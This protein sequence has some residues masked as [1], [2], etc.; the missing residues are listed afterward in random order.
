[1]KKIIFM[2]CYHLGVNGVLSSIFLY[3]TVD[4]PSAPV[5]AF[6]TNRR[7]YFQIHIVCNARILM[8]I[9]SVHL[10][11]Q[12]F[13]IIYE[14]KNPTQEQQKESINKLSLFKE[15]SWFYFVSSFTSS[16]VKLFTL[17]AFT[18]QGI[19]RNTSESSNYSSLLLS[20]LK[21]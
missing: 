21:Q 13:F 2:F 4:Q 12:L 16:L 10:K 20:E 3:N 9:L 19:L 8:L 18:A 5:A 11:N 6:I 1:M 17:E 15:N 7:I 14:K